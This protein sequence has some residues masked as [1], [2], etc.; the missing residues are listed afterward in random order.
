MFFLIFVIISIFVSVWVSVYRMGVWMVVFASFIV[1]AS[2]LWLLLLCSLFI[3]A[4]VLGLSDL[5]F[6]RGSE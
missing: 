1:I 3:V 6:F 4:F 5:R 2:L